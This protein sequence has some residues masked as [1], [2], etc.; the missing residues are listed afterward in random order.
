MNKILQAEHLKQ[1]HTFQKILIYL[2][3]LITIAIAFLLMGGY[4]QLGAYNWWY[5][6]ILPGSFTMICSFIITNDSKRKFHGLFGVMI[7]KQKTWYAK[8][9]LCTIYLGL[10]CL[11]FFLAITFIGF[12]LKSTIPVKNSLMASII[13]FITFSWQIPVLMYLSMKFSTGFSIMISIL[14]NFGIAVVL[15]V[16]P[17]W[18][19]PFAIPSR[20]MCHVIKVLPNGLPVETGTYPFDIKVILIGIMITMVLYV[21]SSYLTAKWFEKQEA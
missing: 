18:W 4:V 7:D 1:K 15:A 13:L 3:P 9:L 16:T 19:I 5:T 2:A 10:S 8:I 12:M 14:C 6:L 17:A 20:I 21:V 11:I